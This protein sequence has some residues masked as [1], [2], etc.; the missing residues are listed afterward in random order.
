LESA[1]T[2]AIGLFVEERQREGPRQYERVFEELEP[3]VR[4]LFRATGDLTRF[5]GRVFEDDRSLV[6]AAR[7]LGGPPISA[8]DLRTLVGDRLG[9]ARLPSHLAER[10]AQVV[11]AA[12][13][14]IRFPWT[15]GRRA[16]DDGSLTPHYML[17][18]VML[19]EEATL[20]RLRYHRD[21]LVLEPAN[22]DYQPI[23]VDQERAAGGV[24]VIGPL[25]SV[26]RAV[27]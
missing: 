23:E 18:A 21:R 3:I 11:R 24:E 13:D 16:P 20:K 19:E 27:S 9:K 10:V 12:W 5:A 8:D 15:R 17:G 22:R 26:L 6:N 4:E 25:R 7:Y 1:R 2:H 14:P